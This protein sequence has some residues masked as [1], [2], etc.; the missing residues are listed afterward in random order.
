[1]CSLLGFK[2]GADELERNIAE[3]ES[4]PILGSYYFSSILSHLTRV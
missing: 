4:A 2:I 1:M 3:A